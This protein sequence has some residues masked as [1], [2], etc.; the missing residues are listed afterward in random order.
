MSVDLSVVFSF[1]N[2]FENLEELIRRTE[3]AITS[4]APAV[5]YELIFVDDSSDDGS[6]KLLFD[7]AEQ[8]KHIRVIRTS[9]RFGVTACV[10]A[11][12]HASSGRAVIYMDSDLQDPPELIPE[13]L[14]AWN[15][16][17]KVVHT[18]RTVRY[19]ESKLK[20]FVTGCAYKVIN[21]F[22]NINLVANAG[23]FKL[24]DR[25]ALN[26]ILRVRDVDPYLRGLSVWV[27][28]KQTYIPYERLARRAGQAKFGLFSSLNPYR[29]FVRGITSFS[30]APL[31]AA[32][33]LGFI[34]SISTTVLALYVVVTKFLGINLPGW[35][36]LM[37]AILG[38]GGMILFT[39]GVLGIYVARIYQQ[40]RGEGGRVII[41]QSKGFSKKHDA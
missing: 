19:G 29:E 32:L 8:N 24:I 28:Y 21:L 15:D 35:S 41:E 7:V 14:K 18:V 39:I 10:F 4:E 40:V 34:V 3:L 33:M 31:Y 27:G 22:S 23:D 5:E 30:V 37:T 20:M 12:F 11:G 2:E 16:G 17:A 6:E 9:R 38:T 36:A 25:T 13:L 1:R 26:E